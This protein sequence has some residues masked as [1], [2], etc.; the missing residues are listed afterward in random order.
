MSRFI[1]LADDDAKLRESTKE[2]LEK[3]GHRVE[4]FETGDQMY[5]AFIN[6]PCDIAILDHH[7]PGSSGFKICNMVRRISTIPIIMLTENDTD[8]EYAD[9]FSHGASFWFSKPVSPIRLLLQIS[10]LTR[11]SG[12][13]NQYVGHNCTMPVSF[14][15]ITLCTQREAAHCNGKDLLVTKTEYNVLMYFFERPR[16]DISRDAF[17]EGVWGYK[18]ESQSRAIDDAVKRLRQK[19]AKVNSRAIIRGIWGYGYRLDLRT[20]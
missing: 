15:D 6:K 7:M 18:S 10:I 11:N 1:Y 8:E 12:D 9:C 20:D 14:E 17:L 13:H 3:E 5:I 2:F 4:C 16:Q 19:M